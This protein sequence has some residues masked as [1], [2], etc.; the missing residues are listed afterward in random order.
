MNIK[1]LSL[2]QEKA[3]NYPEVIGKERKIMIERINNLI[4]ICNS[5]ELGDA[6]TELKD[7]VDKSN[8]KDS[9]KIDLKNS[10]NKLDLTPQK[11]LLQGELS[12]LNNK[13]IV[14]DQSKL[15][16]VEQRIKHLEVY[17]KTNFEGVIKGLMNLKN[18]GG[19]V[20]LEKI[21]IQEEVI[22][23]S[24]DHNSIFGQDILQMSLLQWFISYQDTTGRKTRSM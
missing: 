22:G 10:I 14:F 6:I 19:D 23:T 24:I 5:T 2:D 21:K 11:D 13:Q 8:S 20:D 4:E 17:I 12:D 16:L 9:M 1:V 15:F 3:K 18:Q 7:V